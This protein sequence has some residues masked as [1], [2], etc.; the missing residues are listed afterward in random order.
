MRLNDSREAVISTFT[1]ELE[2]AHNLEEKRSLVDS[3]L[4]GTSDVNSLF[5]YDIHEELETALTL[6][7]RNRGSTLHTEAIQL[8]VELLQAEITRMKLQQE[9]LRI[10]ERIAESEA[11]RLKLKQQRDRLLEQ[12]NKGK[13]RPQKVSTLEEYS[14]KSLE[15]VLSP[16]QEIDKEEKKKNI[17]KKVFE[18]VFKKKK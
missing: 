3:R 6:L 15:S 12:I 13:S 9:D 11:G 17:F 7:K 8:Y 14:A 16:N 1:D 2:V 5:E 4:S 18:S 10:Q